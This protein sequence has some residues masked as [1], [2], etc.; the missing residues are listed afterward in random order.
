L[1]EYRAVVAWGSCNEKQTVNRGFWGERLKKNT[2][3]DKRTLLLMSP[4]NRTPERGDDDE[5]KGPGVI[6]QHQLA[7][8]GFSTYKTTLVLLN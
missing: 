7:P 1:E 2:G 3:R 5:G 6:T 8:A 4:V